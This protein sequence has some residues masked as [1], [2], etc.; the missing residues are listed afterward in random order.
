VA[1]DFFAEIDHPAAGRLLYPGA[2]FVMGQTPWSIR[3]PAPLI[4]QHNEEILCGELGLTQ[5]EF[6]ALAAEGV[7]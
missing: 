7:V 1:R 3:R 5:Q 2:P 4:G 6:Q